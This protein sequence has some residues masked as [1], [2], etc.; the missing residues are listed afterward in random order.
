MRARFLLSLLLCL[1]GL[2]GCAPSGTVMVAPLDKAEFSVMADVLKPQFMAKGILD[3]DGAWYSKRF[4]GA[5][6]GVDDAGARLLRLSPLFRFPD[7]DP[8]SFPPTL[9]GMLTADAKM[10]KGSSFFKVTQGIDT[11][12]VALLALADWN[13]DGDPD[14]LILCRIEPQTLPGARRDYYLVVTEPERSVL[15]PAVLAVR[16]C[17]RGEC[18]VMASASE[19]GLLTDSPVTD[20]LQGQHPVTEPPNRNAP[21]AQGPVKESRLAE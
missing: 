19:P 7:A 10:T 6:K 12:T 15:K 9:G 21:R 14:W 20:M 5:P 2:G 13:G 16:D 18:R 17:V 1:A 4:G 8:A 3:K 11:M